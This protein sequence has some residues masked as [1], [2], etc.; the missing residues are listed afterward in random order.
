MSETVA[1]D[2]ESPIVLPD[3]EEHGVEYM[4]IETP[5]DVN[6]APIVDK[7]GQLPLKPVFTLQAVNVYRFTR[8]LAAYS[9]G[10]WRDQN[11]TLNNGTWR[12]WEEGEAWCSCFPESLDT[13]INVNNV[14]C[15]RVHY[16]VKCLRGGW[17]TKI[18]EAGYAY[19]DGSDLRDWTTADGS[20]TIGKLTSGGGKAAA[21]ATLIVTEFDTKRLV[22]FSFLPS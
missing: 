1:Q 20:I 16:I 4:W 15:Y 13:P 21:D 18:P 6:D 10:N 3:L 7:A 17:K 9:N 5:Q 2:I 19:L 22:S 8:H 11:N 12:S 14:D